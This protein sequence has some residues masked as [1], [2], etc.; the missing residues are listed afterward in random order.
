MLINRWLLLNLWFHIKRPYIIKSTPTRI[1][2]PTTL[3]FLFCRR[4]KLLLLLSEILELLSFLIS[5]LINRHQ[6]HRWCFWSQLTLYLAQMI[7]LLRSHFINSLIQLLRQVW[8]SSNSKWQPSS[9][10]QYLIT[11]PI[12]EFII[13]AVITEELSASQS[14]WIA[15]IVNSNILINNRVIFVIFRAFMA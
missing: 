8:G 11:I 9:L 5:E 7:K 1:P 4:Y 15:K 14:S 2:R 13:Y 12:I 10:I 6:F 3:R